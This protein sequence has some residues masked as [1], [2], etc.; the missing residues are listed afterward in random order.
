MDEIEV[1]LLFENYYTLR[2]LLDD[3]RVLRFSP[4]TYQELMN[5]TLKLEKQATVKSRVGDYVHLKLSPLDFVLI[6][7]LIYSVVNP[8]SL[9]RPSFELRLLSDE[10]S[11]S[12]NLSDALIGD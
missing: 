7:E 1:N 12:Y 5:L 3:A 10:L 8:V 4:H 2:C 6:H 11:C 9:T